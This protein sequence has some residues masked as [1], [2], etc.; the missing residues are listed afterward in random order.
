MVM[1]NMVMTNNKEINNKES[2]NMNK[3]TKEIML[4]NKYGP[5]IH[6]MDNE[7]NET[8][9]DNNHKEKGDKISKAKCTDEKAGPLRSI[10]KRTN[11]E[12]AEVYRIS[13]EFSVAYI[14]SQ[15]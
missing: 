2:N 12:T 3:E 4:N 9:N 6:G 14:S 5:L 13:T 7:D 15:L 1:N 8:M 11:G 10:L